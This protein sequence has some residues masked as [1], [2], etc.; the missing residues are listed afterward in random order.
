MKASCTALS[1]TIKARGLQD[2]FARHKVSRWNNYPAVYCTPCNFLRFRHCGLGCREQADIY[3]LPIS[4]SACNKL[5]STMDALKAEI[6]SK[7]KIL[8]DDSVESLRPTKYMRRGDIERLKQEQELKEREEM[9]RKEREDA[10]KKAARL[11]VC[12]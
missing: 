10:T 3:S 11:K 8:Q 7:R 9:E 4:D 12:I 2:I 5:Q 1:Q 6:A